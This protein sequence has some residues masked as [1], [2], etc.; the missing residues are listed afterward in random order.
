MIKYLGLD[1][2]CVYELI[3]LKS[4]LVN[5]VC[6]YNC[7]PVIVF[8]SLNHSLALNQILLCDFFNTA[9]LCCNFILV[10]SFNFHV[11]IFRLTNYISNTFKAGPAYYTFIY[12]QEASRM[13]YIYQVSHNLVY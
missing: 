4:F 1:T 7:S 11:C 6:P 3:I 9:K 2:K 8:P 10:L 5:E 13:L 12:T